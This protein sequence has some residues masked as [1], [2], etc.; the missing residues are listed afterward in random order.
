MIAG[1]YNI[2]CEQG[3]TFERVFTFYN[4]DGTTPFDLTGYSARMQIRRDI[5]ATTTLLDLTTENGRIALGG[6]EGT[7]TLTLTP[8][9][10][11]ALTDDG[12]YDLEISTAEAVYRVLKGA[13]R[14][15]PEVTR[16]G[17]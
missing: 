17:T 14:L 9:E 11:A 5:D 15:D 10:T 2:T 7:I 12:V 16:I 6:A 1:V 4:Q 8:G 3:A 13:F